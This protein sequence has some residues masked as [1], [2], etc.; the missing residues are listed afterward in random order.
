MPLTVLRLDCSTHRV[1]EDSIAG[2][3]K[4]VKFDI[5][6]TF[7]QK[8]LR[9]LDLMKSGGTS[10]SAK[11]RSQSRQA[12]KSNYNSRNI[13]F[14]VS[15]N[16]SKS[17]NKKKCNICSQDHHISYCNVFKGKSCHD[18]LKI[19]SKGLICVS[20]AWAI[21]FLRCKNKK[22]CLSC[23]RQ[24]HTLLHDALTSS[25]NL[26]QTA[27]NVSLV[28]NTSSE[29]VNSDTSTANSATALTSSCRSST[30]LLVTAVVVISSQ[31]GATTH[32]RALIDPRA[33]LPFVSESL[34]QRL[35]LS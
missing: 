33:E 32:A 23:H 34:V 13:N 17:F 2:D 14:K 12:R 21:I 28:Q 6:T 4:P 11:T 15:H 30:V 24:H 19:Y 8:R 7:L 18:H 27:S 26:S 20:T 22:T 16:V 9:T 10:Q 3:V 25:P 1:W 35:P 29:P 5:L 31:S